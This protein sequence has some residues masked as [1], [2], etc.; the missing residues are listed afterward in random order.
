VPTSNDRLA[1]VAASDYLFEGQTVIRFNNTNTMS[2]T[3]YPNGVED[4]DSMPL[5]ANGVIYVKTADGAACTLDAPRQID[6]DAVDASN[7]RCPVLTV[8]GTY[9]KS[10]TLGSEG[11]ILIDGDIRRS[12]DVVLGLV[13]QRFVR[14]KHPV[15]SGC[16]S[17]QSGTMNDVTIEAA[18]LAL[19]DSFI[20][21]N[22]PCGAPLGALTVSGAIAQKFRGPVGTFNSSKVRNHG[23][24][25]DYRYDDRL[26]YRS[27]PYFLDPVVAAWRVVRNNEQVPAAK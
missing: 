25:K 22:Y 8:R 15:G 3:T 11:D 14:V 1:N 21:D 2:V 13:A 9:P 18:I 20:V 12:G 19:S 6:Y 23:Y 27:P 7:W 24:L 17:N 16:G 4:T 26:R 10:M 5:P